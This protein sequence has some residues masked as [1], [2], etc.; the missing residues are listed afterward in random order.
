MT[1]CNLPPGTPLN[2]YYLPHI[3]K[4]IANPI[5]LFKTN[6]VKASPNFIWFSTMLIKDINRYN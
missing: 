2:I 1:K 4:Q 5:N 3:P 6:T